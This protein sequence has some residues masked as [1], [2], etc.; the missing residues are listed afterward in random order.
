MESGESLQA[1]PK[2]AEPGGEVSKPFKR[3]SGWKAEG[4]TV[5][6]KPTRQ[7]RRAYKRK[8]ALGVINGEY[9]GEPR[10]I[11]RAIAFTLAKRKGFG[12]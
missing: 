7:Q 1:L 2:D 3:R 9:G 4:P 11:R 10:R 12:T 5:Q 8:Q 6:N